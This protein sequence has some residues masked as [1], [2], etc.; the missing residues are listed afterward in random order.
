MVTEWVLMTPRRERLSV[1]TWP[2][3]GV[4]PTRSTAVLRTAPSAI[5][6]EPCVPPRVTVVLVASCSSSPDA[7]CSVV[8]PD[9][10]TSWIAR[11]RC[12]PWKVMMNTLP[13]LRTATLSVNGLDGVR[14]TRSNS[15]SMSVVA[16]F[17]LRI[18]LIAL[19]SSSAEALYWIG[20][21]V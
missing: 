9:V 8:R 21:L 13:T 3:T 12:S 18:G 16:P 11:C 19:N 5:T 7:F 1:Q 15:G 14:V 2:A 4:R 10:S 20:V 17:G 6:A